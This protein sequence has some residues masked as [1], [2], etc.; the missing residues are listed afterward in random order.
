MRLPL[1]LGRGCAVLVPVG[2]QLAAEIANHQRAV[3]G[4][5][6]PFPKPRE[7]IVYRHKIYIVT[8]TAFPK[9]EGSHWGYYEWR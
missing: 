7:E 1:K 3:R 9:K 6:A 2:P 8:Y 4:D 5:Y